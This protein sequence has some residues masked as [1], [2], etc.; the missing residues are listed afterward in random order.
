MRARNSWAPT[1]TASRTAAS[2]WG[3]TACC[4]PP[5]PRCGGGTGC[6]TWA[7]GRERCSCCWPGQESDLTLTGVELSAGD[8]ALA[9]ENLAENGLAGAI[10]TGDIRKH[11]TS[12]RGGLPGGVQP[13]LLPGGQRGLR[14]AGPDG[15]GGAGGLVRRRRAAA[16]KRRALRPGPPAGA[17]GGG[18]CLHERR[19]RG[20]Q[21][22]PAGAA[23]AWTR[24]PPPPWWRGCGRAGRA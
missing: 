23:R 24:R 2:P 3:R 10:L 9:R 1:P 19:R 14:R 18:L 22:A 16:E 8:S 13:A 21:A 11:G 7:A 4:W 6:G 12:R 15:G 5:S 20:A 17:A